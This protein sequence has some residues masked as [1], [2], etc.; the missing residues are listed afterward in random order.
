LHLL[1]LKKAFPNLP[2]ATIIS[3]H[4][5]SLDGANDSQGS[6]SCPSISKTLKMMTQE[7]TRRQVLVPLDFAAVELIVTNAASAVQS[8]N[9]GLVEAHSKLRVE[10]VYKA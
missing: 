3:I 2:Q 10:S 8:C 1:Q 4:Q 9:K 6:S 5:T 7:P